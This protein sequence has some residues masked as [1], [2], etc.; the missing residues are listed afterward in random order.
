MYCQLLKRNEE[1]EDHPLLFKLDP[2]FTV[3]DH[4]RA[5]AADDLLSL[6]EADV[7]LLFPSRLSWKVL[8]AEMKEDRPNRYRLFR[9]QN[10]V[11]FVPQED[12]VTRVTFTEQECKAR[13][14]PASFFHGMELVE[15]VASLDVAYSTSKFADFSCWTVDNIYKH[16][17]KHIFALANMRLGRWKLSEL[18]MEVAR[19]IAITPGLARIVIEKNGPWESVR[20]EIYKACRAGGIN[21]PYIVWRPTNFGGTSM[22]TKTQRIKTLESPLSDGLLY[23]VEGIPDLEQGLEQLVSF[24]GISKSSR[25]KN[26]CPDALSLAYETFYPRAMNADK[27]KELKAAEDAAQNAANVAAMQRHIFGSDPV[28]RAP[29]VDEPT[30]RGAFGIPRGLQGGGWGS[31]VAPSSN[32][33]GWGQLHTRKRSS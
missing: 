27:S 10:L 20:D 16:E 29:I 11:E 17:G 32:V 28:Y 8:R 31:S 2:A 13:I 21:C 26:D 1:D 5:K 25:K 4:A 24:D 15:I 19:M 18:G 30:R 23:F 3:K 14:K 12:D 22:K 9:S 33:G 6:E 7:D